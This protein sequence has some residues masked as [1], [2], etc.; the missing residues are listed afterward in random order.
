MRQKSDTHTRLL[1]R[2]VLHNYTLA[3]IISALSSQYN[4]PLWTTATMT[5]TTTTTTIDDQ[6]KKKLKQK[7]ALIHIHTHGTYRIMYT[8]IEQ[9]TKKKNTQFI[10][11]VRR[12]IS[13]VKSKAKNV[14][15]AAHALLKLA[16]TTLTTTTYSVRQWKVLSGHTKATCLRLVTVVCFVC[17][18]R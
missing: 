6:R 18:Q 12:S 13:L 5:T 17:V 1:T 3:S 16:P 7:S 9:Q 8:N 2:P 10:A 14:M 4:S 15:L 11:I